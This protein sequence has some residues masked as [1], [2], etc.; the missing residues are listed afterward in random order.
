MSTVSQITPFEVTVSFA[1]KEKARQA[2]QTAKKDRSVVVAIGGHLTDEPQVAVG[3]VEQSGG[4][5][6]QFS[7]GLSGRSVLQPS[8][9]KRIVL[10]LRNDPASE[11]LVMNNVNHS[12]RHEITALNVNGGGNIKFWVFPTSQLGS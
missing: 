7:I 12:S 5:G 9:W 6:E 11:K 4:E 1:S 10:E 8:H 3:F 2:L